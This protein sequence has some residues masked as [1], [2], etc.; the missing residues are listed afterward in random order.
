MY[1]FDEP[2][3]FLDVEQRLNAGKTISKIVE[4]ENAAALIIDHDIVFIDYVS[5]R[6]MVF[7]GEPGLNGKATAP[8]DLR[9]S[10]NIFL[11]DLNITFRRDKE[12]KRPRVNK[13]DSYL[14]REQKEEGE[15]YYTKEE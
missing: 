1:L 3:A 5:D 8:T 7:Q 12:T 14:D 11:K 6:A 13:L 2:T 15:Y 10:M 9:T 4:S